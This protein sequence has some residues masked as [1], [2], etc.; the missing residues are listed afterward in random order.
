MPQLVT[1]FRSQLRKLN[2]ESKLVS[3]AYHAFR[4]RTRKGSHL[5][6]YG[7]YGASDRSDKRNIGDNA[8]LLSMLRALDSIPVPKLISVYDC[9]GRYA[10]YGEE[11]EAGLGANDL[12]K[13]LPIIESTKLLLI[14]GGGLFQDYGISRLTPFLLFRLGFLFWLAG[15]KTMWYSIGVGPLD[16]R[17]GRLFT[18]LAARMASPITVRDDE[19]KALLV[20]IGVPEEVIH[21]SADPVVTMVPYPANRVKNRGNICVGLSLLPFYQAVFADEKR[22]QVLEEML[23]EFIQSLLDRSMDVRLLAFHNG[24]DNPACERIA[25]RVNDRHLTITGPAMGVDQMLLEYES[26]DYFIGMRFHSLVF[27][28]ITSVPAG[29]IAYHP[30]VRSLVHSA[31]LDG[32]SLRLED[33]TVDGL[34]DLLTRLQRDRLVI[35]EKMA[36]WIDKQRYHATESARLVEQLLRQA[37]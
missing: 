29:A 12:V 22:N 18:Y 1:R 10:H 23:A 15:R 34:E 8:I 33:L 28:Y 25:A 19:S 13:W 9:E 35:Q 17:H 3:A 36:A 11:F 27:A 2:R 14:G 7:F 5:T 21:V 4:L 16:T 6:L 31:Q 32:Y 37:T 20:D 24:P 26:M 30:K